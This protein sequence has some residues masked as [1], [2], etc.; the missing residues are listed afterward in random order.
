MAY[1]CNA[2][3]CKY[4]CYYAILFIATESVETLCHSLALVFLI[5]SINL[6]I[7]P[8]VLLDL[9]INTRKTAIALLTCKLYN[10][11]AVSITLFLIN[12]S[13]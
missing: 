13:G 2:L 3:K 10:W 7:L 9:T 11:E 5:F 1:K 8:K 12:A 6:R 4:Y